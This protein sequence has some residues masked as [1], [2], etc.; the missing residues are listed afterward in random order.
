[1]PAGGGGDGPGTR[2]FLAAP[3]A[4]VRVPPGQ[5]LCVRGYRFTIVG[6]SGDPTEAVIP[7]NIPPSV[8]P[9]PKGITA[10]T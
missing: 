1:M 6:A 10:S 4:V 5:I 8:R 7:D 9:A 3:A 2:L